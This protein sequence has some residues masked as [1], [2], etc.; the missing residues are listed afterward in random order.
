MEV[1]QMDNKEIFVNNRAKFA[2]LYKRIEKIH[3]QTKNTRGHG[4]DHDL[5]VAQ[6]AAIIAENERVGEMAWVAGLMHSLDRHFLPDEAEM[7]LEECIGLVSNQFT[8]CELGE[9]RLAVHDHSKKNDPA[10]GPV[11]VALKD[12]DRLANIGPIN[13][14][15]GGQHRPDIPACILESLGSRHPDSTFNNIKCC[16]DATFYN[17]EWEPML[18]LPKAK[19]IGKKYFD[20]IREFQIR[21]AEQFREAGLHTWPK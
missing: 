11:T 5:L 19:E 13:L 7:I 6:Y 1:E 18:R 10:D 14:I 21:F 15:R 4:F 20:Y 3:S 12:A 9:I 16:Y 8:V 2:A 17:L